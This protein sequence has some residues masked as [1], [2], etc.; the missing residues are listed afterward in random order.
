MQPGSVYAQRLRLFPVTTTLQEVDGHSVLHIA[1]QSL[2]ELARTF[3]TPLYLYDQT[4]LETS[5]AEYRQTLVDSY[6]G[7]HGLTYAGKAFLCTGMAQW[8]YQHGLLVDCTGVG[9][10]TIALAAGL[11]SESILVHGV[12]KSRQDLQAAVEY[13]G[14]IVVDNL[15][16]LEQLITIVQR[17]TRLSPQ[18]FPD[19]WLRLRPG[20]A[21]ETHAYTQTGQADSKFGT[22]LDQALQLARM[23]K[24]QNLPLTGLHFH[25]GSQFQDPA[26]LQSALEAVL[27]FVVRCHEEIGWLPTVICPG[28]GWGV[29][30]H[31]D[32]LPYPSPV[33]YIQFLAQSLENGCRQRQIPLP[34]L[35][36]EPGR[37]L[38]AQAGVAL[39]R[40]GTVKHSDSRC[41]IIVDGGMADN[42]RPALYGARY[43]ALPVRDVE[44]EPCGPVWLGGPYCESGD[45]LIESLAMPELFPGELV[46]IPVSGAYHLSMASNYNGAMRPA[47]LWLDANGAHL[48]QERETPDRLVYRDRPLPT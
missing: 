29:P 35:H 46:A 24:Q 22:S 47:V 27:D 41:W 15:T 43:T 20:F 30:Y 6:P 38:V 37:G 12:N 42:L 3:D 48:I 5:L 36:L 26:P 34:R 23:C 17:S 14:T 10:I 4:T 11:P 40:V 21:V 18:P 7:P 13:A 31:E 9:E 16:E 1:G 19:L 33:S 32:Q 44:R 45:I 28:G 25:L 2:V 39:Y 8:A